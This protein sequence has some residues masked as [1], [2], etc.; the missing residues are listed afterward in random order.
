M[1]SSTRGKTDVDILIRQGDLVED[2][3]ELEGI[4]GTIRGLE[5]WIDG[6]REAQAVN[7]IARERSRKEDRRRWAIRGSKGSTEDLLET[8]GDVVLDGLM[9][10]MRG[11]RDVEEGFKARSKARQTR[12]EK[13]QEQL[14][15]PG[16][17]QER[18][19]RRSWAN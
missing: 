5:D 9:A 14:I 11:W 19:S 13:R 6:L 17:K 4:Q 18:M 12:R 1:H 15:R 16:E 3:I 10:W 8:D 2:S 7:R